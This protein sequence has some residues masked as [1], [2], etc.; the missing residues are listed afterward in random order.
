MVPGQGRVA[1]NIRA[2][3]WN[4]KIRVAAA[5]LKGRR[6]SVLRLHEHS[7]TEEFTGIVPSDWLKLRLWLLLWEFD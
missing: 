1:H 4:S 7:T 5:T 6:L 3:G 2:T